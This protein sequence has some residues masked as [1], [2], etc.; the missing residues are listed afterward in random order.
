[1]VSGREGEVQAPLPVLSGRDGRLLLAAL[2]GPLAWL[3]QFGVA[4]GLVAPMCAA[5]T[6]AWLHVATAV[7]LACAAL[8]AA[9]CRRAA[10]THAPG[11]GEAVRRGIARSGFWLSLAFLLLIAGTDVPGWLLDPCH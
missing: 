8:G 10:R 5:G 9:A 6:R 1:V 2:S 11:Q 3:A 4:Y 7:A